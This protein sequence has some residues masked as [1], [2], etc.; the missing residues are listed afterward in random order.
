MRKQIVFV[1]GKPN[2]QGNRFLDIHLKS[3][4]TLPKNGWH[5]YALPFV[6]DVLSFPVQIVMWNQ[7]SKAP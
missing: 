5:D 3:I 2:W 1:R 4:F 6:K 7:Y